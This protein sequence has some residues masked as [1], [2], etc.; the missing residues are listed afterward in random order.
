MLLPPG[1]AVVRRTAHANESTRLTK[2]RLDTH[3]QKLDQMFKTIV[4]FLEVLEPT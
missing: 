4:L 1:V 3:G 2:A